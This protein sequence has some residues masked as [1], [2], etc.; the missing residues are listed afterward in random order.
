[1][2]KFFIPICFVLILTSCNHKK[3]ERNEKEFIITGAEAK[4]ASLDNSTQVAFISKPFRTSELSFRVGGL[5]KQMDRYSG[6]F[7]RKGDVIARIDSRDFKIRRERAYASYLQ[8][9][10]EYKRLNT[11]FDQGNISASSFEKAKANYLIA[12]S[13]YDT[14]ENELNDTAL[15]A[16]FDGYI[17]EVMIEAHQEVRSAQPAFR[18]IDMDH[19]K[20]EANISLQA[21]DLC[22]GKKNIQV[23]FDS[24]PEK[25]INATIISISKSTV[26]NNLS[27]LLTASVENKDHLFHGGASGV[28][29]LSNDNGNESSS[30]IL[31]VH[32][33]VNTPSNGTFV[34]IYDKDTKRVNKRKVTTGKLLPGGVIEIRSGV[35][36]G[37]TVAASGTSLL[38]DNRRVTIKL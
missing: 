5:V 37:E 16:P 11:L 35:S 30:V 1:M 2:R 24:H 20:I 9:E 3:E 6:N 36:Q 4:S 31:P 15:R 14:A 21:A 33:L 38:Y 19:L 17:Q 25:M 28:L 7:V 26:K 8:A 10:A 34:W 18:F 23:A 32:T 13:N 29:H 27:F 12:K 22:A